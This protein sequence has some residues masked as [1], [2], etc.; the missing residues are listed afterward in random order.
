MQKRAFPIRCP[1]VVINR[2][3]CFESRRHTW[4]IQTQAFFSSKWLWKLRGILNNFFT[5]PSFIFR[6]LRYGS[7][8]PS[9]YR[10]R[11][12]FGFFR[13]VFCRLY[14]SDRKA[15]NWETAWNFGCSS[16]RHASRT[17]IAEAHNAF[18]RNIPYSRIHCGCCGDGPASKES[19]LS[20]TAHRRLT[21]A[22]KA[23]TKKDTHT[24][25]FGSRTCAMETARVC[26]IR[27]VFCHPLPRENTHEGFRSSASHL[28][29]S[30]TG[31]TALFFLYIAFT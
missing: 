11:N 24:R 4:V 7:N 2:R 17:F 20:A 14:F 21:F 12:L 13:K 18:L 30:M 1:S 6:R 9:V 8:W 19:S 28:F 26:D 5:L 15:K 16:R 23:S 22:V 31:V 25:T 27:G 10:K 3:K 29:E